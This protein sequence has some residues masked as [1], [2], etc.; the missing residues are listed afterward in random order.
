VD[1]AVT[2]DSPARGSI[3]FVS[4]AAISHNVIIPNAQ[5]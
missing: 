3:N 5:L 2:N 4:P 1:T